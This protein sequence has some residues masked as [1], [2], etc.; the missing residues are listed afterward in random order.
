L[1][2]YPTYKVA[3]VDLS[4]PSGRWDLL[5]GTELLPRFPGS[6][7]TTWNV[8]GMPGDVTAV[9]APPESTTVTISLRINAVAGTAGT[10]V[11]GGRAARLKAIHDNLDLLFYALGTARQNYHGLV[12]IRRYLSATESRIAKGRMVSASDVNFD[13]SNDFATIILIFSIPSGVWLAPSFDVTTATIN[14]VGVGVRIKVPAGT[15]PSVEN[16]VCIM[17]P[18][19]APME[20]SYGSRVLVSGGRHGGFLLGTKDQ[21]V[22][23]PANKWTMINTLYWKYGFTSASNDWSAPKPYKGLIEP[24]ARPMG[25]ALT[26]LPSPE[27]GVGYVYV[28]VPKAGTKVVLRT[29]KAYY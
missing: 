24:S 16:M 5:P 29:R 20:S 9:Y 3:G 19:G 17:P 22:T 13:Q 23:L 27:E 10:I 8:P 7:A 1:A 4:D 2:L 11:T 18:G 28:D 14:K 25:S 6:R 26:V 15:A 12:E 21:G